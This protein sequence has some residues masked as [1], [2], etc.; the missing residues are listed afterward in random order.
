MAIK[1]PESARKCYK[2][3]LRACRE[4]GAPGRSPCIG[5]PFRPH[6]FVHDPMGNLERSGQ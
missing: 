5:E 2:T 1:L 3:S 4:F 6:H